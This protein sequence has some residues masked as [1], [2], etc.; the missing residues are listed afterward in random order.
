MGRRK[1]HPKLAKEIGVNARN[2][3][4][5]KNNPPE[6]VDRHPEKPKIIKDCKVASRI[7]DETCAAL[8]EIGILSASDTFI[9]EMYCTSYAE[10]LKLTEL[11]RKEGFVVQNRSGA[12][13]NP[14]ANAWE[15]S[16]SAVLRCMAQMGLTP[17]ARAKLDVPKKDD[18]LSDADRM[19]KELGL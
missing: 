14:N 2:P 8:D 11:V 12:A 16:K 13:A 3:G 15:K 6:G 5:M 4:R 17:S 1:I 9:I 19:C 7:W 10:Y 18:D